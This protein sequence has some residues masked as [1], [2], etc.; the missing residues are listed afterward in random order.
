MSWL[1]PLV[2]LVLLQA[3]ASTDAERRSV[4]VS[5]KDAKGNPV[6]G[7]V[8][9]E[10]ALIENGT[11]RDLVGFAPDD[12][13]LT[14][15]IVVDSSQTVSAAFRLNIYDPVIAFVHRLPEGAAYTLWVTGERPR[16]LVELTSDR[17]QAA[18]ALQMVP[19][20]GGNM[21]LDAIAEA[22]E[23]LSKT[24]G[25]RTAVVV[26]TASGPDFSYREREQAVADGLRHGASFYGL[27]IHEGEG[28]DFIYDYV[29]SSLTEKTGGLFEQVLSYM[30]VE[31]GLGKI[32][33]ELRSQYRLT[34][35]TLPEIKKRKLEV[36]VAREGARVRVGPVKP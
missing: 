31:T 29:L 14:V 28:A 27:R 11:A 8:A 24:E 9:A 20:M 32:G 21:L 2:A 26:V 17:S 10:V 7:L 6:S 12:R 19:P 22:S 15:A 23:D 3:A 1:G 5:V 18:P 35:A 33:A 4:Q 36:R 25:E 13:P 30:S 16:K 34:Y